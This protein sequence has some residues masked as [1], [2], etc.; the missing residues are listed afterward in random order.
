MKSFK[1]FIIAEGKATD[2]VNHYVGHFKNTAHTDTKQF[3]THLDHLENNKEVTDHHVKKIARTLWGRSPKTR[4]DAL[5]HIKNYRNRSALTASS[6][7]ALDN[8]PI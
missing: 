4:E 6:M 7:K 3:N 1:D 5:E 2:L 8:T